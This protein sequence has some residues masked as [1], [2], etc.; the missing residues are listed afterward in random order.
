MGSVNG[1]H[2][3]LFHSQFQ[4]KS[5][6]YRDNNNFIRLNKGLSGAFLD[7]VS[8]PHWIGFTSKT[9]RNM[10]SDGVNYAHETVDRLFSSYYFY[11]PDL[12]SHQRGSPFLQSLA[13]IG[14]LTY[15]LIVLVY[16]CIFT[17]WY[18]NRQVL[19]SVSNSLYSPGL[20]CSQ[21]ELYY[22]QWLNKFKFFRDK[23]EH[24]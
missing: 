24:V 15:F 4:L 8:M 17:H 9:K 11:S 21:T 1:D 3:D 7:I 13:Q 12:V 5:S 16:S 22:P 20:E 6:E 14:G 18:D 19:Q 10:T 2:K 23:Y